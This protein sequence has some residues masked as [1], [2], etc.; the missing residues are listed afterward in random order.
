MALKRDPAVLSVSSASPRACFA[1]EPDAMDLIT[2]FRSMA[3]YNSWMNRTIYD[4][5]GVLSDEDRKRDLRAF[6][7]SI[8]GT[9]NHLLLADRVQMG[10]FVGADRMRSFDERGHPIEVLSLD[11]E[12]YGDF[13]TLRR[14]RE[15]TDAMIEA[16]TTSDEVTPEFLAREMVYDAMSA[17]GRYRVPMWIAVTHFFNHQTHHRGQITTLLSQLGHDP[18]VTDLMALYRVKIDG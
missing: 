4:T 9:L 10:R 16:W 17:A 12:L 2:H 18:G 11:Q 3:Q 5:C 6:F 14:E 13:S 15:K 7:G 8:H 1:T